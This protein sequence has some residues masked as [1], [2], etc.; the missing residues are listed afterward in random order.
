MR[1][2]HSRMLGDFFLVVTPM[3]FTSSGNFACAID[4]RF[5][6][7][8]CA[9]SR[10]V[11]S[12]NVTSR[13][14]WPSFVHLLDMYSIRSTPF[15]SAS[16][17]V[18]TVSATVLALA[19]G[20]VAVTCTV[21]GATS[22]YCAIGNCVS[23]TPPTIRITSDSTVA[24]MGRSMKK[25]E[26]TTTPPDLVRTAL[27]RD[28]GRRGGGRGGGLRRRHDRLHRIVDPRHL[29]PLRDDPVLRLHRGLP[30][31]LRPHDAH[32]IVQQLAQLDVPALH[33]F[34]VVQ[35]QDVLL[36]L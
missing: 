23:A 7:S 3:R 13:F 19:P 16:I 27:R 34:L 31:T 1:F 29:K 8:T 35:H 36:V 26:I 30:V 2:T 10:F 9:V 20:Y 21:G 33:D 12:S 15:T 28:G 25:W 32:A 5:C 4:T 17:G 22:G 24:K 18:A 14:I 6:T 11:P